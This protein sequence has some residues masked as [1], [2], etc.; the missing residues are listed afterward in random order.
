[1]KFRYV[2]EIT[3]D[4]ISYCKEMLKFAEIRHLDGVKGNFEVSDEKE[5]VGTA[6]LKEPEEQKEQSIPQ[7]IHSD[8]KEVVE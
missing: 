2:T 7:L 6:N 1:M 5:Y 4:N 3:K 8:V